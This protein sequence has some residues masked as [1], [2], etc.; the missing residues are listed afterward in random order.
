LKPL[1]FTTIYQLP[2]WMILQGRINYLIDSDRS[3][4]RLSA[5][6]SAEAYL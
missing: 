2:A 1:S 3:T 5:G 6:Y 4:L